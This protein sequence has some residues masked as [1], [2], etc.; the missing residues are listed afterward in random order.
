[1]LVL[2]RMLEILSPVFG[3]RV[4]RLDAQAL[5]ARV[6]VLLSHF[7]LLEL[8]AGAAPI[9]VVIGIYTVIAAV[10]QGLM[11]IRPDLDSMGCMALLELRAQG[12]EL[13]PGLRDRVARIAENDR[14]DRGS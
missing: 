10:L 3:C 8:F 2:G 4:S 6:L 14:F 13:T 1:M 12:R 7:V 11:T 5:G 9:G